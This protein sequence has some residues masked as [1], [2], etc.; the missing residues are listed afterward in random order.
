MVRGTEPVLLPLYRRKLAAMRQREAE[1]SMTPRDA[2]TGRWRAALLP[3]FVVGCTTILDIDGRYTAISG[4]SGGKP[5][6]DAGPGHVDAGR[7]ES[8]GARTMGSG[9][10]SQAGGVPVGEGGAVAVGGTVGSGG[11][12]AAG[13]TLASGG[14]GAGG[15]TDCTT[16]EGAC[17]EGMKC[18]GSD[19]VKGS[20]CYAPSALVGCGPTGCE[21]CSA[22]VPT[23]STPSCRAGACS[24]SCDPGFVEQSGGCVAMGT[25]GSS[26]AGTGGAKG[27]GGATST[28][29]CKSDPDCS[30]N[31]GAAGPFPCCMPNDQCGCT[32][33][34]LMKLGSLPPIGYCLPR[35]PQFH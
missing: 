33:L 24:F 18:C 30:I 4:E 9:G 12:L 22:A 3:L 25:G 29:A 14:A 15:M 1:P 35:P 26:G 17:E 27:S 21:Y 8:G 5:G 31:C 7:H 2:A 32:W 6:S 11:N 19:A 16:P 20:T 28:N 13:G 10:A 34:N 23:N